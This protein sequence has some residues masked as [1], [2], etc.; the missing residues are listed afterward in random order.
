MIKFLSIESR[1]VASALLVALASFGIT[2]GCSLLNVPH[3][4]FVA[5]GMIVIIAAL[6]IPPYTIYR[7]WKGRKGTESK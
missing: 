4:G 2:S 3:D 1:L 7:V 5:L 6:T